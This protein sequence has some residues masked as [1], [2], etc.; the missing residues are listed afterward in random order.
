MSTETFVLKRDSM[1]PTSLD[2]AWEFFSDPRNLAYI[3]PPEMDFEIQTELEPGEFYPGLEIEYQVRPIGGIPVKW[4][5]RIKDVEDR[6]AFTDV[7]LEGPYAFWEHRH[8]FQ[9]TAGGVKMTDKVSYRLP[10]GV[11]GKLA[12]ALVVKRKLRSIFDY[13]EKKIQFLFQ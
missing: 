12:H 5:S 9:E 3:T 4:V 13:R 11:L 10:Y 8:E 7:Q 2:K 1:L 6:K